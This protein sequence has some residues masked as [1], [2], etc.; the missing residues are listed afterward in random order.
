MDDQQPGFPAFLAFVG[1]IIIIAGA[2]SGVVFGNVETVVDYDWG[3]DWDSGVTTESNFLWP[4]A[5]E[6]WIRGLVGGFLLIGLARIIILL[7]PDELELE[8]KNK[9]QEKASSAE[10]SEEDKND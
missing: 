3:D 6:W 9:A 7:E 1:V 5:M 8:E 4:V 2:V 10:K